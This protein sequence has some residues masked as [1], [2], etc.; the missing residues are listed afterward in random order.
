MP[1]TTCLRKIASF[2]LFDTNILLIIG[3]K[4][5][6]PSIPTTLFPYLLSYFLGMSSSSFLLGPLVFLQLLFM[7][8]YSKPQISIQYIYLTLSIIKHLK[9][10]NILLLKACKLANKPSDIQDLGSIFFK[11]FIEAKGKFT[12]IKRNH[13]FL[14]ENLISDNK[15]DQDCNQKNFLLVFNYLVK[16]NS[17][18][19]S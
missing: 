7:P 1:K 13:A 12:E 19:T 8:Y 9:K 17:F 15:L 18:K 2:N 4:I 14:N 5:V 3:S 16:D 10:A 11:D 6:A